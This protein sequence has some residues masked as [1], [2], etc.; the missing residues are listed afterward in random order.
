M[1]S[2]W[3]KYFADAHGMIYVID[4]ADKSRVEEARVALGP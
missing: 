4:A 3:E 1:R 2:I